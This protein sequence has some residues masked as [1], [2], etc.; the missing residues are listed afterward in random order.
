MGMLKVHDI[1]SELMEKQL[2]A[3]VNDPIR[4]AEVKG[5]SDTASP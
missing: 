1:R 5:V 3:L 2:E 4:D